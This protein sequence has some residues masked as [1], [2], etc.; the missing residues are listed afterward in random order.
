MSATPKC[1]SAWIE[2]LAK[3]WP[4]YERRPICDI[5]F[6]VAREVV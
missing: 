1:P 6:R 5:S 3:P 2:W 4:P